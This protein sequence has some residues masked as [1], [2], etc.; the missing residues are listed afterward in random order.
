MTYSLITSYYRAPFVARNALQTCRTRFK[1]PL[2]QKRKKKARKALKIFKSFKDWLVGPLSL[3]PFT[4]FIR[5]LIAGYLF[6]Q[7][8]VLHGKGRGR[9][10]WDLCQH[11]QRWVE[12]I[13]LSIRL[14]ATVVRKYS[15]SFELCSWSYLCPHASFRCPERLR[16]ANGPIREAVPDRKDWICFRSR[17][18]E[19]CLRNV[20]TGHGIIW[21]IFLLMYICLLYNNTQKI[22]FWEK[23]RK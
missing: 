7:R 19:G 20:L 3:T 23:I 4:G 17:D 6:L 14:T 15:C 11:L 16:E 2:S 9:V 21:R 5:R 18:I 10:A 22:W 12:E 8:K 13:F 1:S